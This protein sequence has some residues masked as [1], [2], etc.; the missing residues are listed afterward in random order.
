MWIFK[1]I[2]SVIEHADGY[3]ADIVLENDG[4][5]HTF[6]EPPD[7]QRLVIKPSPVELQ[8]FGA[9]L[10][11][12]KNLEEAVKVKNVI[13]LADL[14]QRFTF[15]ERV[16]L[17]NYFDR[18]GFHPESK[19]Q[20]RTILKDW[21]ASKAIDIGSQQIIEAVYLLASFNF[22]SRERA[23]EILNRA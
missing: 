10:A 21:E 22:F 20:V 6:R 19:A 17:D 15:E 7:L 8:Q 1:N 18:V 5:L 9:A 23:D 13:T 2:K 14:R 16:L 12:R 4:A 3:Q 11:T